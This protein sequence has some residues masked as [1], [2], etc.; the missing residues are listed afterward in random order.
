[1]GWLETIP[2]SLWM[3]KRWKWL[4]PWWN[5]C[6]SQPIVFFFPFYGK[7]AVWPLVS[8]FSFPL[9]PNLFLFCCRWSRMGYLWFECLLC[10]IKFSIMVHVHISFSPPFCIA[11]R[12]TLVCF[13]CLF[14]SKRIATNYACHLNPLSQLTPI[15]QWQQNN[16]ISICVSETHWGNVKLCENKK[17]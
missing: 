2:N 6:M 1:M 7:T 13:P 9:Q 5:T 3:W 4:K 11:L 16:G 14:P 8:T 17:I 10:V 12:S 15:K